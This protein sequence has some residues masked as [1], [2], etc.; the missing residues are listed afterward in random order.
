[1]HRQL[2]E[3]CKELLKD[4]SKMAELHHKRILKKG[5]SAL[6]FYF[7]LDY[8]EKFS[9]HKWAIRWEVSTST[10]SIWIKE[11]EKQYQQCTRL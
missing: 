9:A 2:E 4:N 11:F 6:E 7:M 10:A 5:R 3:Y 8:G 1:M